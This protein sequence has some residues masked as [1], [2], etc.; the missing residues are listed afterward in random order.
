MSSYFLNSLVDFCRHPRFVRNS[1]EYLPVLPDYFR[2]YGQGAE[3]RDQF[4]KVHTYVMFIGIGR[5]GTSLIGALLDAHPRII[6]SSRATTLEI[7]LS[8]EVF[9]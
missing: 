7:P 8:P 9:P 4:D 5:S 2:S 6:I 3:C 1:I